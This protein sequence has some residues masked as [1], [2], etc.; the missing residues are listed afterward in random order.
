[1][2]ILPALFGPVW[3]ICRSRELAK[4]QLQLHLPSMPNTIDSKNIP[5]FK[6][7]TKDY[8]SHTHTRTHTRLPRTH[9]SA[10]RKPQ[11]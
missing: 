2:F 3:S 8:P 4:H 9:P 1:M 5:F 10:I 7:H 11:Q 6:S